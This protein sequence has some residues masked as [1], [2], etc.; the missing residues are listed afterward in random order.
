MRGNTI[1]EV[2]KGENT[3]RVRVIYDVWKEHESPARTQVRTD[4]MDIEEAVDKYGDFIYWSWY[5]EGFSNE[6]TVASMW[7][8]ADKAHRVDPELYERWR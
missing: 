6:R 3:Q 2:F 1:R 5:T 7:A 8:F 4:Y